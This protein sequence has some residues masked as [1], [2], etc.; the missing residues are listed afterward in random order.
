VL[1]RAKEILPHLEKNELTQHC[2]PPFAASTNTNPEEKPFQQLSLFAPAKP[3]PALEE[4]KKLDLNNLTPVEA[5]NKLS[6]IQKKLKED[7]G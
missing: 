3:N 7:K 6:E 2:E 5:L 4:L 1:D